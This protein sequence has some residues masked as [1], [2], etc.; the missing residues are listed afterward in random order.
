[1]TSFDYNYQNAFRCNLCY[2]DLC[3]ARVILHTHKNLN[4][5]ACL[6]AFWYFQSNDVITQMSHS[7]SGLNVR[8][9][10][11]LF[12]KATSVKVGEHSSSTGVVSLLSIL[13]LCSYLCR[14]CL[15]WGRCWRDILKRSCV[16][17]QKCPLHSD[18]RYIPYSVVQHQWPYN[19][20]KQRHIK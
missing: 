12:Y 4:T 15:Q 10:L 11:L 5:I 9:E 8:R 7:M 16:V 17:L 3:H 6:K 14:S 19:L 18:R 20:E 1:M 13:T 2:A